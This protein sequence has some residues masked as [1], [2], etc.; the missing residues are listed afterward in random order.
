MPNTLSAEK[1]FLR[2]IAQVHYFIFTDDVEQLQAHYHE[3]APHLLPRVHVVYREHDGCVPLTYLSVSLL[4]PVSPS[5]W[6]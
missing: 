4:L 5:V 3:T 6:C 2:G 1:Y